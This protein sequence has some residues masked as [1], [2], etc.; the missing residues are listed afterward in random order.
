M[1]VIWYDNYILEDDEGRDYQDPIFN[2]FA[3]LAE[4]VTHELADELLTTLGWIGAT[5][6]GTTRQGLRLY[7]GIK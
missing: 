7:A 3:W 6:T 1:S 4:E 2:Q 5:R